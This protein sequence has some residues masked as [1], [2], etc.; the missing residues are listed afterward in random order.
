[1]LVLETFAF[2]KVGSAP[3][4]SLRHFVLGGRVSDAHS[5]LCWPPLPISNALIA[6]HEANPVGRPPRADGRAHPA[7]FSSV[8]SWTRFAAIL[9]MCM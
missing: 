1:M 7:H 5:L 2:L 4:N 3:Y 6:R 9:V 8:C